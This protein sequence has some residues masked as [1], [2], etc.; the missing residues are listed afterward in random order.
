[1]QQVNILT[2]EL[3]TCLEAHLWAAPWSPGW[4]LTPWA[5][6]PQ[7]RLLSAGRIS[8]HDRS[9][10]NYTPSHRPSEGYSG[11]LNLDISAINQCF[12]S[13][14]LTPHAQAQALCLQGRKE[15]QCIE[16]TNKA[17]SSHCC[18]FLL[19]DLWLKAANTFW[20]LTTCHTVC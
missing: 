6:H 16:C 15:R 11:T 3:P 8:D 19:Y 5:Y 20:V 18:N 13:P 2:V 14:Q 9:W 12:S 1:M 17:A 4:E 7:D 10:L